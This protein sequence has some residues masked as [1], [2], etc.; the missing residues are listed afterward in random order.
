[1]LMEVQQEPNWNFSTVYDQTS[2][3]LLL[4]ILQCKAL[5]TYFKIYLNENLEQ[6][7]M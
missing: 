4:I 2:A 1:M 3:C 5:I 7:L 6:T